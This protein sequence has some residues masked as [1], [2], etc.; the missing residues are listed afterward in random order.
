MGDAPAFATVFLAEA[1][2]FLVAALMAAQVVAGRQA[3][4]MP[5]AVIA[6]E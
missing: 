6:G 2:L 4:P 5:Q 3:R 1:F